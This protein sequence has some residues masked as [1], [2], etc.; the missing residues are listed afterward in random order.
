MKVSVII[1]ALNEERNIARA[2]ESSLAAVA[3]VGS[4]E[5]I[6]ADSVS[7]DATIDIASRYPITIVQLANATERCCGIGGQ[8]GFEVAK[9]EYVYILD[10]DMEFVDGFL[11]QAVAHLD[12]HP[13]LAGVGGTVVEM[14]LVNQ[15]FI[16]R[17]ERGL[18]H[19]QAGD[20]DRLD[21]GGLYRSAALRSVGYFTN[22][23]LCAYEEFELAARLHCAGWRLARLPMA[24]VKHYGHTD[25]SY[26]LLKRRW[27][28]RYAW[29][30]GQ[31]LRESFGQPH[32]GFV[33]KRLHVVPLYSA[34]VLWWL[35]VLAMVVATGYWLSLPLL[36]A[37][38]AVCLL[39]VAAMV[40]KKRSVSKGIY[41][42]VAWQVFA[43]GLVRGILSSS[44]K[45]TLS[46]IDKVFIGQ[47]G[48][49]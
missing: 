30:V 48:G 6:L 31:L 32:L 35:L 16:G 22:R 28:S 1:K 21:M 19:M 49:G 23:N 26:A 44:R 3:Q 2:I 34:V 46:E 37:T 5:V 40:A 27:R 4:G 38:L 17:V 45:C 15:E 25:E 41:S 33:V 43:A 9:G 10:G 12:Q 47:N 39:P 7:N 8:L 36:C 14:N 24:S 18:A 29:G 20:V 42:V 13:A 11:A